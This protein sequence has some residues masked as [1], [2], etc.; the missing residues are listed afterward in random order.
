MFLQTVNGIDMDA[1]PDER[2]EQL[3]TLRALEVRHPEV[4]TALE[5]CLSAHDALLMA[6]EEQQRAQHALDG[7]LRGNHARSFSSDEATRLNKMIKRSD[8]NAARARTLFPRCH[9]AT[10]SLTLRYGKR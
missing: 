9:A 6:E 3:A 8:E 10:R 2:R 7:A 4:K 1:S 5:H